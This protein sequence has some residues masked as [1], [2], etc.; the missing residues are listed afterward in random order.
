M[1]KNDSETCRS[2]QQQQQQRYSAIVVGSSAKQTPC[3]AID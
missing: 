1:M 3:T 2:S